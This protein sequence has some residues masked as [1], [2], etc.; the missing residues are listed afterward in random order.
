MKKFLQMLV[1]LIALI[2]LSSSLAYSQKGWWKFDDAANLTA[3]VP[4][5]GSA[6]ELTG[7][8]TAIAGPTGSNGAVTVP[9]GSYLK[10]THGIAPNGG[11]TKVNSYS[12]LI[13]FRIPVAEWHNFFQVDE[14]PNT[15]DGDLFIKPTGEIGTAGA[16]YSTFLTALNT[17]Y[18]LVIT[19]NNGVANKSYIDGQLIKDWNAY[20]I[21]S[22][23]A[24]NPTL[25]LFA[26]DDGD[27]GDIDVAEVAIWDSP[28]SASEVL[29]MGGVGIL[30]LPVELASFNAAQSNE[31]I[32]LNWSTISEK[33][34]S[35]FSVER[36]G[37]TDNWQSIGFVTG[38]GTSTEK[39]SYSFSDQVDGSGKYSYRLKQIDLDGSFKYSQTVEV[40]T[41]P[42]EFKLLNNYPNPFNPATFIAYELS[43]DAFVTLKVY[44]A[45]GELVA[46]LV[47]ELQVSGKYKKSFNASS[48][49]KSLSSGIYFAELRANEK[50]QRIK[51]MLLK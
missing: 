6:L 29:A 51:M 16:G 25:L 5:Y 15:S 32:V 35:G 33:N 50:V 18:R 22:R 8:L 26:D 30:P 45:T 39:H 1:L 46:E 36:K 37:Q 38:A 10:M 40:T 41:T 7:T 42:S 17:W 20:E 27:D 12:L 19:V 49:Y 34:N 47:N 11:R 44:N 3:A 23:Y 43:T 48:Q 2:T 21:D 14:V 31:G 28:L 9:K 13:D 24:L 4:G